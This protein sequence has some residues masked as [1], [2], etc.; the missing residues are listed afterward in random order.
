MI[1]WWASKKQIWSVW[2]TCRN[3]KKQWLSKTRNLLDYSY[4]QNCYKLIG[5]DLLRQTNTTIPHQ[6]SFTGKL[7]DEL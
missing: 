2:R 3:I 7:E 4:H 5:I 6:I 1:F